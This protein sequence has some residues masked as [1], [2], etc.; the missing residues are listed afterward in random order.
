MNTSFAL[1]KTKER[2]YKNLLIKTKTKKIKLKKDSLNNY[3]TKLK[4]FTILKQ[5]TKVNDEKK[6]NLITNYQ[7]SL[8][9]YNNKYKNF[10]KNIIFLNKK[11]FG[12]LVEYMKFLNMTIE[13][14]K[15]RDAHLIIN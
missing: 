2:N 4:A 14:E 13:E 7:N 9:Y 15:K 8:Y 5:E 6:S 11:F 3:M 1:N 12:K 10:N